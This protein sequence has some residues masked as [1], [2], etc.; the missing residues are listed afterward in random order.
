MAHL[1]DGR[2]TR[3]SPTEREL[4]DR[5]HGLAPLLRNNAVRTEADRR[6]AEENIEAIKDTGLSRS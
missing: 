6:V 4:L 2:T 1:H 5:A 3:T